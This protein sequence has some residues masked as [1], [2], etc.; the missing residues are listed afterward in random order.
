MD[1]EICRRMLC[2]KNFAVV[3]KELREQVAVLTKNL[4]QK[5]RPKFPRNLYSI[6]TNS[7]GC[8]VCARKKNDIHPLWAK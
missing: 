1:A 2:S 4:H 7:I 6:Q 5:F 8:E 3:G